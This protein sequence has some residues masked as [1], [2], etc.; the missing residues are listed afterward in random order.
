MPF[1]LL[2]LLLPLL[3]LSL[4]LIWLSWPLQIRIDS[5]RMGQPQVLLPGQSFIIDYRQSLPFYTPPLS[6]W[7][8][9][10]QQ[11][12]ELP[13]KQKSGIGLQRQMQVVVP[14]QLGDLVDLQDLHGFRLILRHAQQQS[15][16]EQ[17]VFL[18]QKFNSELHLIHIADLPIFNG[19]KA[20]QNLMQQ[21]VEE[22]NLQDPDL[23][24]VS[25]DLAKGGRWNQYQE[26]VDWM[27]QLRAPLYFSPGN[28]AFDGWGGYL[29]EIGAPFHMEQYG[30]W[31]V[32]SL[33]SA[34]G[35]D[36]FTTTQLEWVKKQLGQC[37]QPN[38]LVHLHHPLFKKRHVEVRVLE[39]LEQLKRFNTP[40]I[41]SGHWH[42]DAVMDRAGA[43]I[44]TPDSNHDAT[45]FIVTTTAGDDLRSYFGESNLYHGYR[46]I[47]LA[48]QQRLQ[49]GLEQSQGYR[50]MPWNSV[51]LERVDA[52]HWHYH[53]RLQH[54]VT[55]TR[56]LKQAR[57][58]CDARFQAQ[59]TELKAGSGYKQVIRLTLP[60]Q[61][62]GLIDL[63]EPGACS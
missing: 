8:Q 43:F 50:S 34:H 60:P 16:R 33:N 18:R 36:Q 25:G 1:R 59:T 56:Y 27:R 49:I 51:A 21:L 26:F 61:S 52:G 3:L 24:L 47:V 40:V 19:T 30:D 31:C 63:A 28:H 5:P 22:I 13:I 11:S 62:A 9:R 37:Q 2:K 23:V 4:Y 15:S 44:G 6:V 10:G 58:V 39:M 12:L 57:A 46:S 48:G 45:Q 41:L 7:L 29:T 54:E 20:T 14:R 55:V 38:L 53:N 35:R 17:A 42:Q 32:L